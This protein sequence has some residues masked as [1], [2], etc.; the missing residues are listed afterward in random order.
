MW[1]GFKDLSQHTDIYVCSARFC[2][3]DRVDIHVHVLRVCCII[4]SWNI[5]PQV[6]EDA[7]SF[8]CPVT[9]R[10]NKPNKLEKVL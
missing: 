3:V 10:H 8:L 9:Q 2:C 7:W 6:C 4:S 1:P 5:F